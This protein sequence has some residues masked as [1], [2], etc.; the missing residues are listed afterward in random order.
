VTVF[1]HPAL[2][3]LLSLSH[4]CIQFQTKGTLV[5]NLTHFSQL[6]VELEDDPH[7]FEEEEDDDDELE[8]DV[9]FNDGFC[10]SIHLSNHAVLL[11]D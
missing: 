7:P 11:S 9:L 5:F 3:P 4:N 6:V 8:D 1:V 2:G 10:D